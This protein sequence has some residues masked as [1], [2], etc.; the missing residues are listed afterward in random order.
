MRNESI[1]GVGMITDSLA[2]DAAVAVAGDGDSMKRAVVA[3][4]PKPTP[5]ES[6]AIRR[7]DIV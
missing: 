3:E 2:V 6:A 7:G 4:P 1:V 5:S